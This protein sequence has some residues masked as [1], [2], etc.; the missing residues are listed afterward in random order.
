[1]SSLLRLTFGFVCLLHLLFLWT[2]EAGAQNDRPNI[3]HIFADDLGWGSVGFTNPATHIETPNIDALA[4]GGMRLN[5]SYAA[6]VC[7]PSRA[8]LMTGFHS[9]HSANDRNDNIG[10]GLRAQDVTVAEILSA[11][12]YKNA[13]VGK[14]G[15][16]S[17]GN[18]DLNGPDPVPTIDNPNSIPAVQGYDFFYGYLSHSAAHDYFYS[19]LWESNQLNGPTTLLPNDGGAGGAPEYIH[20]LVQRR[21][22][23]LIRDL[24][25]G[26]DPFYLQV[27]YT[28]PH[29]DL[30]QIQTT[31][32]LN[33]LSGQ[34]IFPAG[35]A[36][37]ANN[38]NLNDKEERYAA[39]I[40]RMDAS[41]GAVLARLEDPNFDDDTSDS[42]LN[43]TIIFFTSDNG[44]TPRD[45]LG[46]VV[47]E[48]LPVSGGLRGGKRDLYEGGI[49]MPAIAY[50]PGQIQAGSSTELINDLSDFMATAAE[51]AGT[52]ARVGTDGVSLLPT[53]LGMPGQRFREHLLFENFENSDLGYV[54]ANWA[55][56]K[57]DYK[58]IQF[59]N[60]NQEL[61]RVDID[62]NEDAPLNLQD[63]ILDEIRNE[64]EAVAFAEG[65][66]QP[67]AYAV[68]FRDW[69]GSDMGLLTDTANWSVTDE[70]NSSEVGSPSETWSTRLV[71][72][73]AQPNTAIAKTDVTLLGLEIDALLSQQTLQVQ[74]QVNVSARN[75]IRIG[76]S[77]RLQLINAEIETA[78]WIEIADG[79]LLEGNGS[80]SGEVICGGKI[81]P[82]NLAGDLIVPALGLLDFAVD[83]SGIDDRAAKDDFFT[84]LLESVPQA[85]ISLDYGI[86]TGSTLFDRGFNDFPA[87]FNVDNWSTS[88]QIDGAIAD[89]DYIS[90][91]IKPAL[92]LSVELVSAGFDF[93][94]NGGN[95]P[96]DYGI[97]S[98]LD[99]FNSGSVLAQT[100]VT[101]TSPARL[102]AVSTSGL[103]TSGELE[104]R[105]YGWNSNQTSGHTHITG[106]D[107]ELLFTESPLIGSG[108]S[109]ALQ[110]DGDLTL[111]E[112]A[113]VA[114]QIGGVGASDQIVV[115]GVTEIDGEMQ[116]EIT[117]GYLPVAGDVV[118]LLLTGQRLGT[119]ADLELIDNG[120]CIV[121][122]EL[123]YDSD[124]VSLR[125]NSDAFILG[126]VNQDG[127]VNFLDISPFIQILTSSSFDPSADTNKD[128]Q[129]NFL[130]IAGFI[131]LLSN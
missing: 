45:G 7:S 51:I 58:L 130:D 128:G 121:D 6:T 5:R 46:A 38:G 104:L 102:E 131:Q 77:G 3:V 16:G 18:R 93:F 96:E 110:V 13:I 63:P 1:M 30:E 40:S 78:R 94:R 105:L 9:G 4:A 26:P 27:N 49:R 95:S 100:S 129:V 80:V 113:C 43:N 32:P 59:D 41:I 82:S 12:G 119:F 69:T 57:Q 23:E 25:G 123:I 115:S 47:T 44:A 117:G 74:P 92:G 90:L 99:G 70:P 66:A 103:S 50:W 68:Q 35:L 48:S 42:I 37:Y 36:Q 62:P 127:A 60:G 61:Y 2:E 73:G 65:A 101:N 19:Y 107:V 31:P 97:L 81:S 28:I 109:A 85:T 106:A 88:G 75:E 15:W 108:A 52:E 29:F 120:L 116:I 118:D 39:M 64:L 24:A 55:I 126:D 76:S 124:R 20:D 83:F 98:N 122:A 87:E 33:D 111:S 14:W 17:S 21:S 79:G 53:L 112:T 56:V 125:F 86:S 11:A 34:Q 8:N 67:D 84:P 91:K 10:A 54:R 114:M 71:H 72:E 89:D 22:E